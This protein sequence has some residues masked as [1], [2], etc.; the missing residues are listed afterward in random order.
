VITEDMRRTLEAVWRIE[1]PRVI[2]R[3]A[4]I[5]RD[6][7]VAEELAQDAFVA[8]LEQWSV[9]GVPAN[10]AAWLTGTA[11]HRAIDLV[12]RNAVAERVGEAIGHDLHERQDA[13][14]DYD[15]GLDDDVGDDR[16]RLIF[17]ACHPVLRSEARVALTLRLVGGLS[18]PEIARAFL[19]PEPT[20]AQRIVRAKRALQKAGVAFELPRGT[21][22]T[23]RLGSVLEVVYLIF[24]EGYTA[25]AGEDWMRPA[26]CEDAQRLVRILERLMPD[27]PEVHG[28]AALVELQSSRLRARLGPNGEPV[29]LLDQDRRLWDRLLIRRGLDALGRAE[30]IGGA[31]GPYVLQAAIAA[32][33]ARARTASETDWRRIVQLYDELAAVSPSPVIELNRAVAIGRADGAAAALPLVEALESEPALAAYH[34]LPSVKGDLLEQL[35]RRVDAGREYERAASLTRNVRERELLVARARACA[36]TGRP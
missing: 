12:R 16:L 26:L 30:R 23:N 1:S 20:I 31:R 33:H 25:T 14:P 35:G 32:C 15:G 36:A 2:A 6:V 34:L 3:I 29:L 4:R 5:V 8:A 13:I 7:A 19:T 28:L 21:E 11:K 10:P 17:V 27:E 22:R 9:S 18:T 24:N